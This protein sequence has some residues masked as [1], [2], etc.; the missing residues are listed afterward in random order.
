MSQSVGSND[1]PRSCP[2]CSEALEPD[3]VF[4]AYCGKKLPLTA[5]SGSK[6]PSARTCPSCGEKLAPDADFCCYCGKRISG[7]ASGSSKIAAGKTD[8][9]KTGGGIFTIRSS[10]INGG[11]S[12]AKGFFGKLKDGIQNALDT[13]ALHEERREM[14]KN[15]VM[16]KMSQ[17][18]R[19]N[20]L[21]A[22]IRDKCPWAYRTQGPNRVDDTVRYVSIKPE[23]VSL[24]RKADQIR[25]VQDGG[26]IVEETV[27]TA[28]E[29][30]LF[31][32]EASGLTK[33]GSYTSS[34]VLDDQTGSK[35]VL[36][37]SEMCSIL[38]TALQEAMAKE[39]PDCRFDSGTVKSSFTYNTPTWKLSQG[40]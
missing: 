25:R 1:V 16:F 12:K 7:S 22:S 13:M 31:D 11:V 19:L 37:A 30:V 23:G 21:V 35:V 20:N 24:C 39:F 17:S 38:G 29:N 8:N 28:V 15:D 36:S 34:I 9:S 40:F 10:V 26:R 14:A 27:Y 33:L 4:C 32:F 3:S 2:F 6:A 5:P 18:E